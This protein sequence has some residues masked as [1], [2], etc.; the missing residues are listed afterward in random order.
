MFKD[1]KR[2]ETHILEQD[3]GDMKCQRWE[4]CNIKWGGHAAFI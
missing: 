2:Y 3:K 4:S 1:N